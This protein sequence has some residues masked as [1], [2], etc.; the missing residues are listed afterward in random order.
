MPLWNRSS[1]LAKS[2]GIIGRT[3]GNIGEVFKKQSI[4]AQTTTTQTGW[5]D[6]T[7]NWIGDHAKGLG[8]IAGGLT[9]AGASILD[10][11]RFDSIPVA[12][13]ITRVGKSVL[14]GLTA[15]NENSRFGAFV[16]GLNS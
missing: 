7:R 15:N 2:S 6:K 5:L 9:T 13:A 11:T 16:S 8:R 12:S 1:S 10:Y 3:G 4:P 14:S